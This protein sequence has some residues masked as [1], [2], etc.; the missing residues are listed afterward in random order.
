M[1]VSEKITPVETAVREKVVLS[2]DDLMAM[3]SDAR[4]EII[5]GEL[6][7]M[8]AAGLLHHFLISNIE[9]SLQG[10]VRQHDIGAVFP[11]GLTYLMA[12]DLKHLKDSFVPDLSF[13]RKENF[14]Q[15]WDISRPHPGIP[16]LAIEVVSPGDDA[17]ELEKKV[18]TYLA[19]GTEQVWVVYPTSKTV[20]QFFSGEP[21]KS[22]IYT[23]LSQQIDTE[24]IF[25][26]L[27][28]TLEVIFRIPAWVMK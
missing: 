17:D 25:P 10:Y 21:A 2:L 11:D 26:N 15:D 7:T 18:R 19:K 1:V 8:S 6:S 13:I 23:E 5:D 14:P 28:L 9:F 22:L 20:H 24:A 12:S 16:N 4:V 27:M 3:G